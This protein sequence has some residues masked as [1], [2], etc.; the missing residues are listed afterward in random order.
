M[1]P[2]E[3]GAPS[4]IERELF[5]RSLS[6]ERPFASGSRQL[7][8]SM[9]PRFYEAGSTI[10]EAGTPADDIVFIVRGRVRLTAPGAPPWEFGPASVIGAVDA[11]QMRPRSRSARAITDVEALVLANDDRLEVLEDNFEQTRHMIRFSA[12]R[13]HGL[14][15]ELPDA[16]VGATGPI[17]CERCPEH[18]PLPLVERVLTLRD[19]PTFA[20]SSIQALVSLAPAAEELRLS[21]EQLMFRAGESYGALFVV[22]HGAI[23][24]ENKLPRRLLR[25]GPGSLLLGATAFGEV[26]HAYSARALAESV[27]L[28]LRIEDVFD[29]MEDHFDLARSVFADLAALRER[30]MNEIALKHELGLSA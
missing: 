3:D 5:L 6:L 27:V 28:R 14:A 20:R 22:A 16:G 9:R 23:E 11:D 15:L 19:V 30:V 18:A 7:G 29:V 12:E 25:F 13:L 17:D 10:Y 26:Q 24:L 8:R 2:D 1:P 4:L 21:A